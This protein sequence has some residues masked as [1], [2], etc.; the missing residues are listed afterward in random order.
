MIEEDWKNKLTPEQYSVLREKGTEAPFTGKFYK[1]F[2]KGMYV[3][4]ACGQKLFSSDT[5]FDS[6]C[7]WPSFDRGLEGQVE[8]KNDD[9]LGMQRTEVLCKNCGSHLGHVF[10]DGPKETTGK[11]FCINS[12]SLDF[13]PL[14]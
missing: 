12:I 5:K 2:E 9:S 4:G 8:F 11:R 7:G 10:D 3:C 1:N 6:D 13:K 14:K